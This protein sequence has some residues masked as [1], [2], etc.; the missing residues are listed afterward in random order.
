M[1][2]YEQLIKDLGPQKFSLKG[3]IWMG[4]LLLV[5]AAGIV[6]RIGQDPS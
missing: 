6:A 5:T 2:R 3:K 1:K 4:V